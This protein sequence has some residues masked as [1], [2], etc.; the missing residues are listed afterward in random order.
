MFCVSCLSTI[1]FYIILK[2]VCD[3]RN[4]FLCLST[5]H[6]YIILKQKEVSKMQ[7]YV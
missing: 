7:R 5:I 3:M 2:H 6:F 1:H 4:C